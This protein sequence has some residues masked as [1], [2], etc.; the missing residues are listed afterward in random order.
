[1]QQLQSIFSDVSMVGVA[2]WLA[3]GGV[4][5]VIWHFAKV[6]RTW[7]A[8][9]AAIDLVQPSSTAVAPPQKKTERTLTAEDLDLI[10]TCEETIYVAVMT[11]ALKAKVATLPEHVRREYF[12]REAVAAAFKKKTGASNDFDYTDYFSAIVKK[13]E[14]FALNMD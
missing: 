10:S 7:L 14:T 13:R 12:S 4:A 11:P 1:V 5:Y 3:V 6:L 2:K 9:Q 8:T